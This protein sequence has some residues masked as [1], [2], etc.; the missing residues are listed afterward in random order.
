[1]TLVQK[2]AAISAFIQNEKFD[3]KK[4]ISWVKQT[5]LNPSKSPIDICKN[6]DE[7]VD[8]LSIGHIQA[9]YEFLMKDHYSSQFG[10]RA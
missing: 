1:M 5:Q 2:K 10:M 8:K 7:I 9:L 4:C 3:K 6:L